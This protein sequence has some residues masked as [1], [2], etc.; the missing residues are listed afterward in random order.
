L[1]VPAKRERGGGQQVHSIASRLVR[2]TTI[3]G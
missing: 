2:H 1:A 3:D